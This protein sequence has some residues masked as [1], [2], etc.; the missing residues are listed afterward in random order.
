MFN[1]ILR[2]SI[3]VKFDIDSTVS[4]IRNINLCREHKKST[5]KPCDEHE[6][7][8]TAADFQDPEASTSTEIDLKINSAYFPDL[9]SKN[10]T[11]HR[12]NK[13]TGKKKETSVKQVSNYVSLFI[14]YL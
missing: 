8:I 5:E 3:S 6:S 11:Q 13:A 10:D 4:D 1:N 12:I 7:V 2:W 9:S 14:V